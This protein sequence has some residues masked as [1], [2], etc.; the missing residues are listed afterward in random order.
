MKAMTIHFDNG[1]KSEARYQVSGKAASIN[2]ASIER[3][4]AKEKRNINKWLL[5]GDAQMGV[6]DDA[7]GEVVAE[8]KYSYNAFAGRGEYQF[9]MIA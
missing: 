3:L 5:F 4:L 6:T 8:G 9:K 7:T 2:E 1:L